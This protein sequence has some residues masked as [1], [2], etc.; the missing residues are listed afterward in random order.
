MSVAPSAQR[1]SAIDTLRGIVM[2]LMLVDHVRE[3]FF[4]HRQVSDPMDLAS[5]DPALFFTRLAS[6]WCAPIFVFL[7]G[8]GAWCYGQKFADPRPATS[9]YL[10]KRGLFLIVLEL[11]LINFAWTFSFPPTMIYLQ[12]IWAIGMSMLAL[13][14]LL[15]LPR[16]WQ[17]AFGLLIVAGHNL[18]DGVH[19]NPGDA[20]YA[21][22]AIL[23]DR[24]VLEI[25][26]TLKARTSYPVL[27]WIGVILLGYAAG[28]LYGKA[29]LPGERQQKL[30]LA[31]VGALLLFV[32][33]RWVDVYGEHARA[34]SDTLMGQ[35]MSWLNLTKY[36]ASLLFL[37]MTLGTGLLL[38]VR[39][40]RVPLPRFWSDLGRVPMFFYVLHLYLLHG[41]YLLFKAVFGM[42][43]ETRFGFDQ[44]WQ[45]WL[46]AALVLLAVYPLCR[47]FAEYKRQ[48]QGGWQSYF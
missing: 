9:V 39:L 21:L 28:P 7:T 8:L 26:D 43:Q 35:V 48:H 25:F 22:W 11:T 32:L 38:L 20:A 2:A 15:W 18:L 10:L 19:F 16:L 42:N 3:Y 12:I 46:M 41:L 17:F 37:L 36:P 33:L 30:I 1:I 40:E 29:T 31:G 24:S 14:A 44:V 27:P 47:R 34:A 23:H 13:A 45:I 6:H 4:L 5:V